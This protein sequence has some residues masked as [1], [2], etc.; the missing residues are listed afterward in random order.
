MAKSVIEHAEMGVL[1]GDT[2]MYQERE[3]IFK[4]LQAKSYLLDSADR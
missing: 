2:Y 1:K 4:L 3:N